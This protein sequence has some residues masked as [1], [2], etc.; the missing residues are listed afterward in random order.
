MDDWR[1]FVVLGA[2]IALG[3]GA[4]LVAARLREYRLSLA[5][6]DDLDQMTDESMVAHMTRL[7]A[8]LGYRV[9]RPDAQEAAFDLVLSDGLGQR[10]GVLLRHWRRQ[11]DE[12]MVEEAAA[13]S[14]KLGIAS[15]MVVTVM[16]YTWKARQTANESGTILWSLK[17]LTEAI[18]QVKDTAVAFPDL[19]AALSVVTDVTATGEGAGPFV[20]PAEEAPPKPVVKPRRRP[21]R[22]RR[23][24]TW[25]SSEVPK[26]P[27]CSRRMVVRRGADGDYWGCPAF[28]RCLG[29]RTKV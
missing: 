5:G 17:E 24:Q 1:L 6:L 15:P 8:A 13:E 21:E 7:F 16:R 9:Q 11:V 3:I 29:T 10:R 28:P 27:R 20:K 23:G 12:R 25:D 4:P 2:L 18:G 19:P 22:I 14:R 26:C